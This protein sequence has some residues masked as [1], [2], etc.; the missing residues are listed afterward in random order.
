M[1]E[2]Y[3]PL[4]LERKAK[5]LRARNADIPFKVEPG[6]SDPKSVSELLWRTITRPTKM[7]MFSPIILSLGIYTGIVFAFLYLMLVTFTDV[8][9][10]HYGFTVRITGLTY[11]GTFVLNSCF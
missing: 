1:R 3:A 4:L 11:L 9:E 5:K 8:Y 10:Q 7:I 2:T 6:L